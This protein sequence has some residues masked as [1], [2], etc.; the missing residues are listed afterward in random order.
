MPKG[1]Q[2]PR[3]DGIPDELLDLVKGCTDEEFAGGFLSMAIIRGKRIT[4]YTVT[5]YM[6]IQER[7]V[8]RRSLEEDGW[9]IIKPLPFGH[10]ARPES[11][12]SCMQY[13]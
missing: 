8:L 11:D 9:A 3:K 6:M 12:M 7:P 4:P 1:A 13:H 10:P 5:R 2:L